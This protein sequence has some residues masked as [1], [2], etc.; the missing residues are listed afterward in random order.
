MK[1]VNLFMGKALLLLITV[2]L[3]THNVIAQNLIVKGKVIDASTKIPLTGA[4]IYIGNGAKGST[5]DKNG[6]FT[7]NA[8]KGKEIKVSF[9]GYQNS[10]TKIST[11]GYLTIS[12]QVNTDQISEVVVTALGIKKEI[13]KIG[14]ATTL[15]KGDEL[16]KARD[17]NALQSLTGKVAGLTIGASAEMMSRPQVV[18]RGSTDLLFV[19]DGVPINSDTWNVSADDIESY[20]VLKGANA[21]ALYGFRGI[22]GAIIITTKRGSKDKKGWQVDIN[23]SNMVET[24]FMTVPK[25]QTEYG[26]GTNFL[27]QYAKKGS[28]TYGAAGT[29]G[30]GSFGG[31]DVL[32]DNTQRLQ[33]YGPRF[34]GQLLKQY[35]SPYDP[36]TGIRTPTPWTARGKNNFENFM[37]AGLLSTTNVSLSSSNAKYD[38][39][40][41]YSHTYQKGM[42]PNTKFNSDNL[43]LNTGYNISDKLRLEG[44]LNLNVQYSPNIPDVSYG[45]NSYVYMFKVYGSADYDIKDLKNVYKGPQGI[46]DL[47]QYAPEYGRENSAEFVAQKWLRTHNKTDVYGFLKLNYKVNKDLNISLRS[48]ITTWN[49]RRT[50]IVPASTNLNTYVPWYYF[51]WYGDFRV[52]QRNL[53]E[54]NTDLLVSYN[55]NLGNWSLSANAGV[56]ERSF[57]YNA[58]YGTTK[59][60]TLPNVY[61]LSNSL[62]PSLS[63]SYIGNMQVYSGYYSVDLGYKNYFNVAATG[64]VDNLSTLPKGSNTFFY[65][66]LS[67]SSVL[68]DYLKLPKE[69]SLLKIRGSYADVKG[70]LTSSTVPSAYSAITGNSTGNLLGYGTDLLTSYDGPT[71][72]NQNSYSLATNYNGTNAVNYSNTI[73]N[74]ALKPYN[75]QSYETGLDVRL[76]K[77]RIGFDATYFTSTNGPLIYSLPVAPS[78]GYYAQNVNGITTLKRG[79]ELQLNAAPFRNTRGFSWDINMNWS[80][81]SETLKAI[82]GSEKTLLL[83]GHN[84]TVGERM[85]NFYSTKFVRDQSGN[86]VYGSAGTPLPVPSSSINDR[87]LI[88]HLNPDFTFG[89]SNKF[90][91]KQFSLSFQFDGRIGGKIYDRILYQGNNGGTSLESASGDYGIAR[92]AEW[93]STNGATNAPTA[94]YVGKGVVI[95]GGTPIYAGG[96]ITN[97][98][99]L[100]FA[101]NAKAVTVQSYLSSGIGGNFDEYYFI[102]RS[103]AK[104]REVTLSYSL[105][106]KNSYFKSATFSLVGR[107]LLYFAARKDFDI[108]QYAA[109]FNVSDRSAEGTNPDLQ[110]ATARRFG[111]NVNVGF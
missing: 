93:N 3:L 105:P 21:A 78:T 18:L 4:S 103:F 24:S 79:I 49:Q 101:P 25:S 83:N 65:P 87:G 27:Y 104:L 85:D 76:F 6:E 111:F 77:N 48:Q 16:T 12:L 59:A 57:K 31:I 106:L 53:I 55:K 108:E 47:T 98:K 41:S 100:S 92:R 64:R 29:N 80:T 2:L 60:L 70:G 15:I 28:Y 71:Y 89:I 42:S 63:Y 61:T 91:Y 94:A 23:T 30:N 11:D 19:V 39:R 34:E 44:N 95:T 5:S 32:Y 81:Y 43:N 66:S 14:Y 9:V 10:V 35:D 7:V 84:Y 86:V 52:D 33:E 62:N 73:A 72:N 45:P 99:D 17:V 109:G 58:N 36:V 97:F 8:E 67:V 37:E 51:G 82:Y 96:Q 74:P 69:I 88:G 110:S 20:N 107:N 68:S 26:R 38:L 22:N 1:K 46:Q 56:S 13:K 90:S 75:V 102:N 40:M 50:E 54:N